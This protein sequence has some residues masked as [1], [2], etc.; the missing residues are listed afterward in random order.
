MPDAASASDICEPVGLTMATCMRCG[1]R[2]V[3]TWYHRL[4][5]ARFCSFCFGRGTAG[6]SSTTKGDVRHETGV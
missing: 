1:R 6:A 4:A 5:D 3:P 2:R